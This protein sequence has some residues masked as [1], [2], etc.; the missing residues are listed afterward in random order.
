MF[1]WVLGLR[2]TPSRLESSG[3]W[4][5][6]PRLE[7]AVAHR[8]WEVLGGAAGPMGVPVCT[9]HHQCKTSLQLCKLY[10]LYSLVKRTPAL[11]SFESWG[12]GGY[13]QPK[14]DMQGAP[15]SLPSWHF[16]WGGSSQRH[17]HWECL[18]VASRG[19]WPAACQAPPNLARCAWVL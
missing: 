1:P 13:L 11:G 15:G 16:P 2:G 7:K 19:R 17:H 9:S 3:L 6:E 12:K 5:M 10:S 4:N 18:G 8:R 14:S